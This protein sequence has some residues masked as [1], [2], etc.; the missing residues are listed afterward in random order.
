[1]IRR[2]K[3]EPR[4]PFETKPL[5]INEVEIEEYIIPEDEKQAVLEQLY[6]FEGVPS[7]DEKQFDLHAGKIFRV[8]QFRVTREH[9][10]NFLVS[11]FYEDGGGSVIDWLPPEAAQ[12]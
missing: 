8:G 3:E 7:L 9:G 12:D 1:M 4:L 10:L 6:P 5:T 2:P 11:P